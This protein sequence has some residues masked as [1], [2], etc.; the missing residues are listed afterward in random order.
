MIIKL[1]E[2][3]Y[4]D[5]RQSFE[6]GKTFN[7]SFMIIAIN[8]NNF[9]IQTHHL[10][11][12]VSTSMFMLSDQ[13]LSVA[14]LNCLFNVIIY[15]NHLCNLVGLQAQIWHYKCQYGQV[16]QSNLTKLHQILSPLFQILM[17]WLYSIQLTYK[18]CRCKCR[19]TTPSF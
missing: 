7:F 16:G 14:I 12:A 17:F 18:L 2:K 1:K 9:P 5:L 3:Y 8:H 10:M 15:H 19:T 6:M 13:Q 11:K 4:S